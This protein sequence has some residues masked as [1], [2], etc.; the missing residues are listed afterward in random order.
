MTGKFI[1]IE[2]PNLA[3]KSTLIN[4][5]EVHFVMAGHTV[6]KTREPGGT[7][8]GEAIRPI[9]KDP[10]K[11]AGAFA[12]S[13][14][15]NGCRSEHEQR[16]IIPAIT[17]GKIVLCDRYYASTE[18][19]QIELPQTMTEE[20]RILIRGVHQSFT[21]AA[22]T[23][24]LIPTLEVIL[25]RKTA[26]PQENDRFEGQSQKEREVYIDYARKFTGP[27]IILQ[28]ELSQEGTSQLDEVLQSEK[29]Q[30]AMR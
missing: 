26:R 29:F 10:E 23:I 12:T 21:Q 11:G 17:A 14:V 27:K 19:Y 18:I 3:G 30:N 15:F 24:F 20:Q 22:I 13:L 7:P 5:L 2:G 16:I 28:P 1:V 4:D 8:I 25:K 6:V 9:L